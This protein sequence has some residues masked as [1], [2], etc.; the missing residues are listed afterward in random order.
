MVLTV[1]DVNRLMMHASNP[2]DEVRVVQGEM[3]ENSERKIPVLV[4]VVVGL[5][6]PK[7]RS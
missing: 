5:S 6:P 7:L 4:V 1:V 2:V 3:Y